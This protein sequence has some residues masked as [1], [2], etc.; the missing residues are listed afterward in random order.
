MKSKEFQHRDTETQKRKVKLLIF[1][2]T[3]FLCLLI[4]DS[5]IFAQK[6]SIVSKFQ[7]ADILFSENDFKVAKIAAETEIAKEIKYFNEE[8]A[9]GKAKSGLKKADIF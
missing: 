8:P 7:T 9:S 3:I 5:L 6:F 1:G 2:V 4:F